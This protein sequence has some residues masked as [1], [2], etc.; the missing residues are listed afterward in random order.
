MHSLR[1]RLLFFI[2]NIQYTAI[3]LGISIFNVFFFSDSFPLQ[4]IT[5]Y[6]FNVFVLG[7]AGSS[8]L[9]TCFSGCREQGLLF[10]AMLGLLT[11]A[12][13]L[14]ARRRLQANKL[15]W[16][17]HLGSALVRAGSRVWPSGCG[18]WAQLLCGMWSLLGP[19]LEPVSPALA[20]GFLSTVPPEKPTKCFES[21]SLCYTVGP[22]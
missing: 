19:G 15:Q 5:K 2:I 7:S 16:L 11:V 20:G 21:S 8:L 3:F 17:Q 6:C 1:S 12:A 9:C 10:V 22:C 14:V 4:V 13:S 18:T